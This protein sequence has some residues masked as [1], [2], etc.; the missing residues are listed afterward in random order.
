MN[1]NRRSGNPAKRAAGKASPRAPRLVGTGPWTAVGAAGCAVD[2]R[3]SLIDRLACYHELF[4]AVG[5]VAYGV[6]VV[7]LR[8]TAEAILRS[9]TASRSEAERFAQLSLTG[10]E[11]ISAPPEVAAAELSRRQVSRAIESLK[12]STLTVVSPQ[13]HD[14]LMAATATVSFEDLMLF[15]ETDLMARQGMIWF[16]VDQVVNDVT[17]QYDVRALSWR[18]SLGPRGTP[19]LVV[20]TWSRVDGGIQPPAF[21]AIRDAFAHTRN[22]FPLLIPEVYKLHPLGASGGDPAQIRAWHEMHKSLAHAIAPLTIGTF[23]TGDAAD[24]TD[25]TFGPRYLFAFCR[26]AAQRITVP[27]RLSVAVGGVR[28]PPPD[29]SDVRV[30]TLRSFSSQTP[31]GVEVAGVPRNY[32]HR[33]VV[34]M[35]KVRQWYPKEGVHKVIWRGPYIKGPDGAPLLTGEVV[36]ALVR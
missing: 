11:P 7:A 33:W 24:D 29:V 30:A 3:D 1:H 16:P 15:T 14:L 21:A 20:D 35:H 22:K 6:S 32:R 26:L 2:G 28:N 4:L 5:Q 34:Q 18:Y 13:M 10:L 27:A 23:A 36:N 9:S 8:E 17:H 31:E 12:V 19:H 25:G